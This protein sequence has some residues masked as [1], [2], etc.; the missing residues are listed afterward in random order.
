MYQ[1]ISYG[2]NISGQIFLIIMLAILWGEKNCFHFIVE[3]TEFRGGDYTYA[4]HLVNALSEFELRLVWLQVCIK[5]WV[6][7]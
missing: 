6:L 4:G 7:D 3:D 5:P 2:L 1:V